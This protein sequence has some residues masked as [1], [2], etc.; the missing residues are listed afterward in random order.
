[1]KWGKSWK[2]NKIQRCPISTKYFVNHIVIGMSNQ[3]NLRWMK[4]TIKEKEIRCLNFG[5]SKVQSK[6]FTLTAQR[7]SIIGIS[8]ALNTIYIRLSGPL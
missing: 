3:Q 8:S 4:H 2:V 1:M 7:M 5:F 6:F